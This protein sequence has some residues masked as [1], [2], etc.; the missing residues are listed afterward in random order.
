MTREVLVDWLM[1]VGVEYSARATT[2]AL[3]VSYLDRVLAVL[4]VP[5]ENLQLLAITC[6]LIACKVEETEPPSIADVEFICD[7][8]Y[9]APQ[10]LAM[11]E[12][13]INLLGFRLTQPTHLSIVGLLAARVGQEVEEVVDFAAHL[14]MMDPY[15]CKKGPG[16]VAL[17]CVMAACWVAGVE[18][19]EAEKAVGTVMWSKWKG[20]AM[21]VVDRLFHTWKCVKNRHDADESRFI[22]IRWAD[23]HDRLGE[24]DRKRNE[25]RMEGMADVLVE[26]QRKRRFPMFSSLPR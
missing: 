8:L 12:T 14:A 20:R 7:H 16:V 19:G 5:R 25:A 9:K 4:D 6:M 24:T 11:E 18:E 22:F 2:L 26:R 13:V 21:L 15:T 23:I 10:V 3:A 17:G 1:E